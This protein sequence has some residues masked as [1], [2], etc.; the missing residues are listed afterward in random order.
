[1]QSHQS[2]GCHNSRLL[3]KRNSLMGLLDRLCSPQ[4]SVHAELHSGWCTSLC[5][6]Q[7]KNT[8]TRYQRSEKM[9]SRMQGF[10]CHTLSERPINLWRFPE[11]C[12]ISCVTYRC[13][14]WHCRPQM[15]MT[16]FSTHCECT[17]STL[18][19]F[20]TAKSNLIL[21]PNTCANG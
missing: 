2:P 7:Q 11:K 13:P 15:T 6:A 8:V 14:L 17:K 5:P 18:Y 21:L 10:H 4:G 20:A 12:S 19:Y 16:S 9:V 1:M 3:G